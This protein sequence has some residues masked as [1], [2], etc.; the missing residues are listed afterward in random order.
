MSSDS[1]EQTMLIAYDGSEN[2]Q[3]AL[4]YAAKLLK[5]GTV[6][7]LTAWEPIARQQARAASR[8]GM[9]QAT[10]TTDNLEDDPAYAEAVETCRQGIAAA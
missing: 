9:H 5:P 10:M 4:E 6:Q 1:R 8:T 3:R 7:I 2:A